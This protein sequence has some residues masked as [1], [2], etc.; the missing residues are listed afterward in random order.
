MSFSV[1]KTKSGV[2]V[3]VAKG[4][5]KRGDA[6]R[7][8]KA[9]DRAGRDRHGTKQLVLDSPGGLV[10][11]ALMMADVMGAVGVTTVVRKGA[12]CASACASILFVSGKYRTVEKGGALAIH[13]CYDSRNGEAMSECNAVISAHADAVGVSGS[14]MMALQEAAGSGAIIVFDTKDAACFGLTLKPG[15]RPSTK[16]PPC[17]RRN[18]R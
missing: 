14:T 4:A 2:S 18:R 6:G 3:V 12:I 11:E 7:L 5:I 9:L 16:T 10:V 1:A 15:A 8:L 17:L 13:S